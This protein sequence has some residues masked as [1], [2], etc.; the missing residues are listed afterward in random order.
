MC[1][2]ML[3]KWY[4]FSFEHYMICSVYNLCASEQN[5]MFWRGH[6]FNGK[7][8]YQFCHP[9]DSNPHIHSTF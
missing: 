1:S 4:Y 6:T 5:H 9:V 8:A 3:N 2:V 7:S